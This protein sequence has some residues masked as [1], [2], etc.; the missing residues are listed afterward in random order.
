[1]AQSK[2]HQRRCLYNILDIPRSANSD[3]I[4]AAYKKQ[5]KRW[6]PD[7]NIENADEA[8]IQFKQINEAYEILSDKHERGWYDA[9]RD[10]ILRGIDKHEIHKHTE[11][12]PNIDLMPYF[13]PFVFSSFDDNDSDSFYS[14]YDDLFLRII[15]L[16]KLSKKKTPQF[17]S[18]CLS[19]DKMKSFYEFWST[20]ESRRSFQ[21]ATKY[22]LKDA[23]N[24][25]VRKLMHKENRKLIESARKKWQDSVLKL[26]AFIKKRDPR[27]RNYLIETERIRM[28][29]E[30]KMAQYEAELDA[31]MKEEHR[32]QRQKEI[33]EYLK[34]EEIE[35]VDP[36]ELFECVVC[37][38]IFKSENAFKSHQLSK[39]HLKALDQLKFQLNVE[40]ELIFAAADCKTNDQNKLDSMIAKQIAHQENDTNGAIDI[41]YLMALAVEQEDIINA[42]TDMFDD[43]QS[44]NI[45]DNEIITLLEQP[46]ID[47][48]ALLNTYHTL[49]RQYVMDL[50]R[51]HN[52]KHGT[53]KR[54]KKK[55][56]DETQD[57]M[58]D[59]DEERTKDEE[60]IKTFQT[61]NKKSDFINKQKQKERKYETSEVKQKKRRRRRRKGSA[62]G[63][64]SPQ[65]MATT[66]P[67]KSKCK[68]CDQIFQSKTKLY[69]HLKSYPKHALKSQ[70]MSNNV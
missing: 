61:F 39:K 64:S 51:K 2:Q 53:K 31:I 17:G 50:K 56:Y 29:H 65:K 3:E 48:E 33:D 63:A 35:T 38:K 58:D 12:D 7:R 37:N 19:Y 32:K 60:F 66:A 15:E 28:E 10:A 25:R 18:H 57:R 5:A 22:N 20:F 9:H 27:F 52:A 54:K 67:S 36:E 6:H 45:T 4:K 68:A 70:H 26:V 16:E 55:N 62:N 11:E 49:T 8:T 14:V 46:G 30:A 43:E 40:N 34:T 44:V 59:E 47:I 24:R 42:A 1:M 41:D 21:F 23:S 13:N 69:H